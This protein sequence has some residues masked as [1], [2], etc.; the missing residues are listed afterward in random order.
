VVHPLDLLPR[1]TYTDQPNPHETGVA[2]LPAE[3]DEEEEGADGDRPQLPAF[4]KYEG[5]VFQSSTEV[6]PTS[7]ADVVFPPAA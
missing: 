1:L 3:G 2:S 6:L 4:P 5:L 7:V